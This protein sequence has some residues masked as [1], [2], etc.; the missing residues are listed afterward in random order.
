MLQVASNFSICWIEKTHHSSFNVPL[1]F[2]LFMLHSKFSGTFKFD[3]WSFP[4]YYSSLPTYPHTC[5]RLWPYM[6]RF[7]YAK[8][9]FKIKLIQDRTNKYDRVCSM[10]NDMF[11]CNLLN[12]GL[13][14]EC[15]E[16]SMPSKCPLRECSECLCFIFIHLLVIFCLFTDF[17]SLSSF[18]PLWRLLF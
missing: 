5:S 7:W 12:N 11:T 18:T 6:E 4:L 13:E 14:L 2:G 15:K 17:A 10:N 16:G 9:G 3:W 8:D 1:F